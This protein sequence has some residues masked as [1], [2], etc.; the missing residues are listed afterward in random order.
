MTIA[1][2]YEGEPLKVTAVP[3]DVAVEEESDPYRLRI[4]EIRAQRDKEAAEC[5]RTLL[6]MREN[7]ERVDALDREARHQQEEQ[8][9]ISEAECP[10]RE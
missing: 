8:Y 2:L 3:G 5:D 10:A 7:R 9:G 1:K 6:R 4:R